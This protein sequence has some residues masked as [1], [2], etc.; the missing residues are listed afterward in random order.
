MKILRL[1]EAHDALYAKNGNGELISIFAGKK[2]SRSKP[3]A[4]SSIPIEGRRTD[5]ELRLIPWREIWNSLSIAR[6]RG[7]SG[8]VDTFFQVLLEE[9]LFDDQGA[10]WEPGQVSP[11]R[12]KGKVAA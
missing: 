7:H 3:N 11:R 6:I 9:S 2:R 10:W 1:G 5:E 4:N 8:I 12:V